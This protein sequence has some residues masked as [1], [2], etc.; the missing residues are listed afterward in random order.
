MKIYL[1]CLVILFNLRIGNSQ[2]EDSL[3]KENIDSS[4]SLK[5]NYSKTFFCSNPYRPSKNEKVIV[6]NLYGPEIYYGIS[7]NISI[8]MQSSWFLDPLMILGKYGFKIK[9]IK[10]SFNSIFVSNLWSRSLLGS[11]D[12]GFL[13]TFSIVLG[14]KN[15]FFSFSGGYSYFYYSYRN[16]NV[17]NVN[18]RKYTEIGNYFK[19]PIFSLY[20]NK[21]LGKR[22]S[23]VSEASFA[24]SKSDDITSDYINKF[25]DTTNYSINGSAIYKNE[26]IKRTVSKFSSTLAVGLRF[27]KNDRKAFQFSIGAIQFVNVNGNFGGYYNAKKTLIPFLNCSWIR[28]F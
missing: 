27:Q 23:L 9:K 4:D 15:N 11:K 14:K 21:S 20:L 12:Y 8:G 3:K 13:S 2:I 7:K 26:N 28:K 25:Q 24:Y 6:Y 10:Y 17:V 5:I 19:G 22:V 18:K 1:L 16:E